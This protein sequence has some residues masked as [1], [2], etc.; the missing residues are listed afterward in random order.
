LAVQQVDQWT[1]AR[2]V[3]ESLLSNR[4]RRQKTSMA[5]VARTIIDGT[6]GIRK[7]Y[8]ASI[9][10]AIGGARSR[11]MSD[12]LSTIAHVTTLGVTRPE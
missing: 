12:D 2:S 6:V 4:Q 1:W 7:E 3:N 11:L 8:A 5:V 10:F 9:T